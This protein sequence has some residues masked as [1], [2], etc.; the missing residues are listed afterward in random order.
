MH[1]IPRSTVIFWSN[2]L[3]WSRYF[4]YLDQNNELILKR[5]L[6]WLKFTCEC[7]AFEHFPHFV[8]TLHLAFSTTQHVQS[9]RISELVNSYAAPNL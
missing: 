5:L 8:F 6:F 4:I 7:I 1:H 9:R 3:R 2:L